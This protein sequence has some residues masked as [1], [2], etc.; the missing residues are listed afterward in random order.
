VLLDLTGERNVSERRVLDGLAARGPETTIVTSFERDTDRRQMTTL[1][2][3]GYI[4]ERITAPLHSTFPGYG[5]G[6]VLAA[7]VAALLARGAS[8]WSAT[9]LATA[10]ASLSVERTTGY[11]AATADPVAAL[12]LFRPLAY[13]TDEACPRYAERFGVASTPIPAKQGE[14]ARLKFAPPKNRIVY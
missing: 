9:V 3:N 11:G 4:Y 5:A 10:L 7:G 2:S 1:F 14:G 8:P 12:D 6:E 13:L